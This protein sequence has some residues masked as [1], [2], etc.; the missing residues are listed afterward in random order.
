MRY[1]QRRSSMLASGLAL[2]AV[3]VAVSA[4]TVFGQSGR[5]APRST[6]PTP[7]P[8]AEPVEK[9]PIVE[10]KGALSLIVGIDRGSSFANIPQYFYDSV[11]RACGERL[12]DSPSVKA[13]IANREMNRGEAVKRAKAE[14]ESHIVWLHLRLDNASVQSEDDLRE[15]YIEYIVFAPTTAKI[16]TSG[17]TY[18]QMGRVGGVIA[19][20]RPGGQASLPYTEQL[21]KRAARDAADRILSAMN[22]SGRRV[23]G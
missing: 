4:G 3:V 2:A 5:R 14:T 16:V 18:Q 17:Q 13:D 23:P 8:R 1:H 15:V 21:L 20:P 22:V 7:T 12:D 9:Q 19:M 6:S 11:L 10:T